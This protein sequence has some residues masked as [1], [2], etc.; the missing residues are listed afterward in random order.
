[1]LLDANWEAL[2]SEQI[3]AHACVGGGE[4]PIFVGH[5]WFNGTPHRL[6][7]TSGRRVLPE[8]I[9]AHLT[10]SIQHFH[11]DLEAGALVVVEPGRSRVR[12]L[13]L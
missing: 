11:A 3:P 1:M 2:P 13:P 9:S 8:Q 10:R 6:S 12:V 5:E 7:D 4:K